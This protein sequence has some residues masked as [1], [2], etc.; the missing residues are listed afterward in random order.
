ML[1]LYINNSQ[2]PCY[3]REICGAVIKSPVNQIRHSPQFR[4]AC[5]LF[6]SILHSQSDKKNS[7]QSVN[8]NIKALT[9]W[10]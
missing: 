4:F 9:G 7:S 8:I 6:Q 1:I 3:K 2:W 10:Y 5:V